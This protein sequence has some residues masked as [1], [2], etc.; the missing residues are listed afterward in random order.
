[1]L[2][3]EFTPPVKRTGRSEFLTY[4]APPIK[5]TENRISDWTTLIES[6]PGSSAWLYN[7]FIADRDRS[8][9]YLVRTLT[10]SRDDAEDLAVEHRREERPATIHDVHDRALTL[11]RLEQ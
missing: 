1:M 8:I 6:T 10:L 2:Q 3:K 5:P 11:D 7:E 4:N 9:L